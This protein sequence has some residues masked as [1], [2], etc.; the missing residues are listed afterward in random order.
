MDKW[1]EIWNKKDRTNK[2]I[3]E[4]LIK[5]D[6]FDSGVGSFTVDEWIEYTQEFFNKLGIKKEE[7][8]FDVGCGAG[9]FLYPLY[10]NSNKIGGIDYSKVLIDLANTIMPNYCYNYGEAIEINPTEKFDYVISHSVFHYFRNLDYSRVVIQKMIEKANYKIGIFDVNDKVKESIYNEIRMEGSRNMSKE[11]YKRK[12]TGLEHAFY[13]K[14]WFLDLG[15]Q[16]GLKVDIYDQ[17]YEKY[18]NSNLRYNVIM[19]K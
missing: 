5:A 9:A 15:K 17:T 12:Y 1:K 7:S 19:E 4:V 18:G 10:L 8:V 2:I 16:F 3:L 11:D 13:H 6:G 14:E